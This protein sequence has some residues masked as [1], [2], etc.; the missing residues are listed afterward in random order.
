MSNLYLIA[1]TYGISQSLMIESIGS[2][3]KRPKNFSRGQ[4]TP[5]VF[6]CVTDAGTKF[7]TTMQGFNR[8]HAYRRL[9][10]Q[11]EGDILIA[12]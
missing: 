3:D 6:D 9:R 10:G 11:T 8:E 4:L 7:Q 1:P 2:E 12:A 5:H